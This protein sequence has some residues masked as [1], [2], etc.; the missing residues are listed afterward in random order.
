MR[1]FVA[2]IFLILF[3]L[4]G[5]GAKQDDTKNNGKMVV[6]LDEVHSQVIATD[7]TYYFNSERAI[8]L[9]SMRKNS[10]NFEDYLSNSYWFF[11][12]TLN[13]GNTEAA[14]ELTEAFLKEVEES[15][16]T[17]NAQWNYFFQRLLALSYIRLG[18]QENCLLNHSSASCILPIRGNGVH[19]LTEGSEKAIAI[20]EP[21]LENYPNDLELVWLL[22]VCYQTLGRFPEDVPQKYRIPE[23]SF[24]LSHPIVVP[25]NDVAMMAGVAQKSIAGGSIMEDFNNDGLLDI[26]ATSSGLKDTDQMKLFINMGNG[27]F[28]DKTQEAGLEGLVGGLNCVQTDYNNDGWMDIFVLRGGWFGKWGQHPNSLLRNNRDGTFTDVTESSGL[29]SFHPTQ[30]ATWADFNNDGWLDVYIGNES[31]AAN[32]RGPNKGKYH[33][34]EFYINRGNGTFQNLAKEIGLNVSG[35]VKGV[36]AIDANGDELMDI[37]VSIMG[38]FNKLFINKGNLEFEEMAADFG[39][40]E[41]FVSFP[42]AAFDYDN[43]G[44]EDLMVGAYTTSNNPIAHEIAFELK[45]NSPTAAIPK[46]FRNTGENRFEDVTE[47]V[48]LSKSIYGM[49]FNF[50]DLDNDGFLDLY[51]GTGDP[52]FESI[53]PNR[54][55]RNVKG[56]YFEEVTYTGGFSNV[57]KGHGI[58]WGD[59]DNDGDQDIYITM[60]GAH[61]GDIYQNQLLENPIQVNNWINIQLSSYQNENIIGSKVKIVLEDGSTLFRR[62]SSGASFGGNSVALELGLGQIDLI[63]EISVTWAGTNEK[64]IFTNILPNQFIRIDK[65]MKELQVLTKKNYQFKNHQMHEH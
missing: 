20:I 12:E 31:T 34:N 43:D 5:C 59:I 26:V 30:T 56:Q 37:Y 47:K 57:Q 6:L 21:L 24:E 65:G 33:E 18:E 1:H 60:G 32:G 25:F 54:M 42:V 61:E 58:S 45:G 19:Q 50:G 64:S 15:D 41:P 14:I 51:F 2:P 38:G 22:N 53:I 49:G 23:S 40:S 13:S 3:T 36:T 44:H 39:V 52:N 29:L 28:G 62:V 4:F 17:L 46:L 27:S 55:F 63:K 10:T 7:I 48:G 8:A 9:D 11:R 16:N 35:L